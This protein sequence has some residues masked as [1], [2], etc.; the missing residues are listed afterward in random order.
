[1]DII[2]GVKGRNMYLPSADPMFYLNGQILFLWADDT[3]WRVLQEP[4]KQLSDLKLDICN[5]KKIQV[6]TNWYTAPVKKIESD[7]P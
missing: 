3:E 1:M 4:S 5:C 6:L 2:G 7:Q